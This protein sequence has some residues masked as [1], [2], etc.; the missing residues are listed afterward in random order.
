MKRYSI[1]FEWSYR[2]AVKSSPFHGGVTGSNPV[3]TTN[4]KKNKVKFRVAYG[5]CYGCYG[6]L[7]LDSLMFVLLN[8]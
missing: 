8:K 7:R 1:S 4:I 3:G 5:V 6:L 2:Q